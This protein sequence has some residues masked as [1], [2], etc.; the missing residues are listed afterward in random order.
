MGS[1]IGVALEGEK[2]FYNFSSSYGF[3]SF[4]WFFVALILVLYGFSTLVFKMLGYFV[5]WILGCFSYLNY[6][7]F[8]TFAYVA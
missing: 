7:F 2:T 1:D 8:C 6:A 4:L 5:L 3:N